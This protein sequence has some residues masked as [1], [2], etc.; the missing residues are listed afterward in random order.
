MFEIVGPELLQLL[1]LFF[2]LGEKEETRVL[3]EFSCLSILADN[4]IKKKKAQ[5]K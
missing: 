5:M 2:S 1:F 3:S 4:S